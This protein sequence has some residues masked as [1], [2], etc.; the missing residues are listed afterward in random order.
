M[1]PKY[2]NYK[3]SSN[4]SYGK[5]HSINSKFQQLTKFLLSIILKLATKNLYV[6][7]PFTNIR[8]RQSIEKSKLWLKMST[9][10]VFLLIYNKDLNNY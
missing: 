2:V 10:F 9:L 5:K 3:R 6:I 7:C 1:H 4:Q 8:D